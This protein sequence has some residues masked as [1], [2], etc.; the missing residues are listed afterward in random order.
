MKDIECPYCGAEQDINH[1]D[2][3]GYD[4]STIH[5]QECDECNKIFAYTT[6]VS[7]S[8]TVEQAD[9]LNDGEHNWEPTCTYPIEYTKMRCPMC[10]EERKP[11]PQEWEIIHNS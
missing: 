4:E 6:Y 8:Y 7:F 5:H 2:G 11:T 1:D 10:G 9:C 3:V